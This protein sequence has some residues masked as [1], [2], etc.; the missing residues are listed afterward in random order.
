MSIFDERGK[1]RKHHRET[2][3]GTTGLLCVAIDKRPNLAGTQGRPYSQWR[4]NFY[5]P[6]P[7]IRSFLLWREKT[8]DNMR[9]RNPVLL[10]NT[11]LLRNALL[12]L[13]A[14]HYGT[15]NMVAMQEAMQRSPSLALRL[16]RCIK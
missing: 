6:P 16:L 7:P 15:H 11:A 10:A 4:M 13:R 12:A 5:I 9:S 1:D 2:R 3:L 14:E 8:S